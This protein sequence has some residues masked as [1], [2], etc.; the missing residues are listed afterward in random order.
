M[1]VSAATSGTELA[2]AIETGVRAADGGSTDVTVTYSAAAE[3]LTINDARS[4]AM[5]VTLTDIGALNVGNVLPFIDNVKYP[6]IVKYATGD[7]TAKETVDYSATSGTLVFNPKQSTKTFSVQLINDSIYRGSRS[8]KL[9]LSD[10]IGNATLGTS[11]ATLNIEDDEGQPAQ[12]EFDAT[13]YVVDEDDASA[14]IT[15]VRSTDVGTVTVN[16]STSQGTAKAGTDYVET[17]GNLVFIR[18]IPARLSAFRLSMT[19]TT[20]GIKPSNSP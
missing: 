12:V 10:L 14:V 8:V 1:D 4:R 13:T 16:Y 9:T 17:T 18:V 3:T 11:S 7:G 5:D 15:V 20:V 19:A 2:A 6:I